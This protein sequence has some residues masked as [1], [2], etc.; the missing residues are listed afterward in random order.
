MVSVATLCIYCVIFALVRA[1][2]YVPKSFPQV[3][4]NFHRQ[5]LSSLSSRIATPE[6]TLLKQSIAVFSL[7]LVLL[8]NLYFPKYR[9]F[10]V[11]LGVMTTLPLIKVTTGFVS[12][13]IEKRKSQNFREFFLLTFGLFTSSALTALLF[14]LF[15]IFSTSQIRR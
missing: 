12:L 4:V 14:P 11:Y 9:N 1:K 7:N 15:F 10:Q 2:R 8:Q 3:E 13:M 5:K 6:N